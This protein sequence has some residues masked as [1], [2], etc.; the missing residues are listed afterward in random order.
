[1]RPIENAQEFQTEI[2][3]N[4]WAPIKSQFKEDTFAQL[5]VDF[6]KFLNLD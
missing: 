4:G 5:V 2:W 6:D 3:R 1:M